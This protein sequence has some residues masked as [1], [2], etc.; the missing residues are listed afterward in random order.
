[1]LYPWQLLIRF[2]ASTACCFTSTRIFLQSFLLLVCVESQPFLNSIS[3]E[4]LKKL[5]VNH[6]INIFGEHAWS[7]QQINSL[8]SFSKA[9]KSQFSM[10][11]GKWRERKR[12]PTTPAWH[13]NPDFRAADKR[14]SKLSLPEPSLQNMEPR[15]VAYVRHIG[16]G[17][18]ISNAWQL[19]AAWCEREGRPMN[20]QIGLHHSNPEWIP[21][22]SCRYVACVGIDRQVIRNGHVHS[23]TIPGGLHACFHIKGRYGDLLPWVSKILNQ[24][25]PTSGLKM[26]TTPGF[27]VYNR[28]H[29]LHSDERFDL[30]YCLPITFY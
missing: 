6:C 15:Q 13:E 28:N 29:F 23:L 8:S 7:R 20:T 3:I 22:N 1:M 4:C 27:A 16:Y 14:I 21:L 26:Q 11:P 25:L 17:K 9:F 24:W 30:S 10:S 12:K 19:L 18:N 2:L 5:Q